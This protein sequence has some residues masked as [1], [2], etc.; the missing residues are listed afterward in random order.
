MRCTAL[1][2][3]TVLALPTVAAAQAA[4]VADQPS[5]VTR[6]SGTVKRAPDQAWVSI[7]AETR[8][9]TPADAQRLAAEA[10]TA[11]QAALTKAGLPADAI[12]TTAYSLQPDTEWV[13]GRA[14]VRGYVARNQIEV[15][16]D[17]LDRLSAVLDA[18]GGSGATSIAGLR[19]DVRDRAGIEREALRLAVEDALARAR[20]I[21]A[22]ARS[23]VGTIIRIEDQVEMHRPVPVMMRTSAM[24]SAPAQTPVSPGEIEVTANV[25][26]TI[27]IR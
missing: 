6:G 15:R 16:V 26:L 12:K 22:G 9:T 18:A 24:E 11:T 7:A 21:A 17:A 27:E 10:M 23:T 19:F 14:R 20:A 5:I 13:N 1:L 25:M 3:L 8:A 4:R 2:F